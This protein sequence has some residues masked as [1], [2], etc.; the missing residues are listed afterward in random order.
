MLKTL[1]LFVGDSDTYTCCNSDQLA[2]LKSSAKTALLMLKSCSACAFNFLNLVCQVACSP[3]QSVFMAPQMD[4]AKPS[5]YTS[6]IPAIKVAVSEAFAKGM[7]TSCEDVHGLLGIQAMPLVCG[8][9]DCSPPVWLAYIGGTDNGR[10]P[11]P[12]NYE[13]SNTP[14]TTSD[15]TMLEPLN[16]ETA[17][18][19][20]PST[21]SSDFLGKLK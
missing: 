16:V 15:G 12:I 18:C 21:M 3:Y 5:S 19:N 11:F 8:T 20:H 10:S 14:V 13:I 2:Y 9:K 1:F 4:A 17:R 6:G 7:Y